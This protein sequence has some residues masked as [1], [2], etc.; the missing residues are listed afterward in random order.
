VAKKREDGSVE[1]YRVVERAISGVSDMVGDK[2][3][4]VTAV[5]PAHL[6]PV[7]GDLEPMV[8]IV[9]SL[10]AHVIHITDQGE[11][12]VD[13]DLLPVGEVPET[14]CVLYGEPQKLAEEGPW[15]V[16]RVSSAH[17]PIA[18]HALRAMLESGEGM[19][20]ARDDADALPPLAECGRMIERFG[21]QLWVESEPS[22]GTRLSFSMQLEATHSRAT[23]FSLLRDM[24]GIELP[25]SRRNGKMLLMMVED[26]AAANKLTDEFQEAGYSVV[27]AEGGEDVLALARL[28]RPDLILL[29]LL[30]LKPS[31]I[32]V[33]LVLKHDSR[34]RDIPVLFIS[35]TQ[36]LQ[37]S[38]QRTPMESGQVLSRGKGM[39]Q[40]VQ[41]ALRIGSGPI[42]QVLIVEPDDVQRQSMARELQA[43]GHIVFQAAGPEEA[44]A[45]AERI[46]PKLT[47]VSAQ[48]AQERDYWL[49]R[50]LRQFS[51][52]AS[53]LIISDAITPDEGR[54]AMS[55]GASGYGPAAKL[56]DLI[57][58][59]WGSGGKED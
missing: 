50:V 43:D 34:T 52:E 53:I 9:Q 46:A 42:G 5:Y 25:S 35:S 31:A 11:V 37:E 20:A 4:G 48:L 7:I 23:E 45:L 49:L 59:I 38:A 47:L 58:R 16:V 2:P 14:L 51:S 6:P 8:W 12:M 40:A 15:V 57:A 22:I 26:G 39:L 27:I 30:S 17:A 3:I 32:D 44:V 19:A 28:R 36:D 55:R 33:A 29:D 56:K 21:G 1:L 41:E 54:T 13:A 10:I 24:V 18:E